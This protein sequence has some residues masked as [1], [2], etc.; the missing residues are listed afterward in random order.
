MGERFDTAVQRVT[1]PGG[2]Q[3]VVEARRPKHSTRDWEVVTA[4]LVGIAKYR[5][6]LSAESD[7][8]ERVTALARLVAGGGSP[9]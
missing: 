3:W 7:P 9:E 1:A 8:S 4:P 6:S 2:R 5:E